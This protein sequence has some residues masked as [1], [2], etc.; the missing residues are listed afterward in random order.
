MVRWA[1]FAIPYRCI[2]ELP[3]AVAFDPQTDAEFN[4]REDFQD[5]ASH[6]ITRWPG[7][8]QELRDIGLLSDS[9]ELQLARPS[10]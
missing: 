3:S 4:N 9:G 1:Q 8:P 10:T 7:L 6:A 2:H 5:F